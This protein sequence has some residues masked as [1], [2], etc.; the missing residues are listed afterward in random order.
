VISRWGWELLL[1][2]LLH[3]I[4]RLA[5][6]L[7]PLPLE[8]VLLHVPKFF[9]E[10]TFNT[11]PLLITTLL[12]TTSHSVQLHWC[13]VGATTRHSAPTIFPLMLLLLPSKSTIEVQSS[14][15]T[16]RQHNTIFQVSWTSQQHL[17]PD[18]VL[19]TLKK[20]EG[21]CTIN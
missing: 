6:L 11:F 14:V 7:Q 2:L 4:G 21:S 18:L 20:L 9:A 19:K 13:L 10:K 1:L 12:C 16:F 3:S 8:T 15:S 17:L 5:T